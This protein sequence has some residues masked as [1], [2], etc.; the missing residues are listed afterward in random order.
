MLPIQ[1]LT[2]RISLAANLVLCRINNLTGCNDLKQ[3]LNTIST[4]EAFFLM[5]MLDDV[6]NL[7]VIRE[8]QNNLLA[9]TRIYTSTQ[10]E[11][12]YKNPDGSRRFVRPKDR[13]C[14]IAVDFL[15]KRFNVRVS[16][17]TQKKTYSQSE[18]EEL[19]KKLN[20]AF[21]SK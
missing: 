9:D 10:S 1:F 8:L 7:E 3:Q 12:I 17:E 4:D 18:I 5:L 6:Q 2:V 16:F 19:S 11:L 21:A 15:I 20:A 13:I 14:D